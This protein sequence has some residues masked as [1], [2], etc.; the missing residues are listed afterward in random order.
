MSS[1]DRR[2][3]HGTVR[4]RRGAYNSVGLLEEVVDLVDAEGRG[5]D[6]RSFPPFQEPVEL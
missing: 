2:G 4:G 3:Q 5:M 1:G 6:R